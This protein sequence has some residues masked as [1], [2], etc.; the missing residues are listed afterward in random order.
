MR[1]GKRGM[2]PAIF[3]SLI[4][5]LGF[6]SSCSMPDTTNNRVG[7]LLATS[8]KQRDAYA[9][10][11]PINPDSGQHER[12]G[13]WSVAFAQ[14]LFHHGIEPS[15][16]TTYTGS[17]YEVGADFDAP[18]VDMALVLPRIQSDSSSQ[19]ALET[20]RYLWYAAMATQ[21]DFGTGSYMGNSD[22]RR[23]SIS[24]HYQVSSSRLRFPD[25]D[26]AAIEDYIRNELKAG[27]PLLLYI[28][29]TTAGDEGLGHALVID[30]FE[31]SGEGFQV[32]LNFGWEG[33][34]DGWYPFWEKIV[35]VYGSFDKPERWVLAISP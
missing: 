15:G 27:R 33:V 14:I 18:H 17:Y 6:S 19:A 31:G 11:T 26:K 13:C 20:A 23:Q 22:L 8:W 24:E 32:H 28:E 30:G 35:S 34:S 16:E 2:T 29:G 21:K 25:S 3:F 5:V 7:P 9:A 1:I 4:F 10:F 12:L